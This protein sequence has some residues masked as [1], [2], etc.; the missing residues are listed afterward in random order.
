MKHGADP[1]TPVALVR[2][3]TRGN[4]QT[5]VGT[6]A[7]IADQVKAT[8]FQAPAVCVIG[9]VVK[10]REHINWFENRPLFGKRIIVTRT[11]HQ[12]GG[13][14]KHLG[15]LG[16]DVIELPTIKI[17]EPKNKMEFGELVQDC[18]TYDWIVFTS[19]NGVDAFFELFY[20]LY[21]DA[22][23]IGPAKIAVIGPGTA[24][25]VKAYHLAVD[26]MPDKFVAE[27]L[28][29]KFKD[30]ENIE[31]LK[32]L[33]VRAEDAREVIAAGL[34]KLGAIVDEAIA[35]RTV[36]ER[37]DNQ[38]AIA[39]MTEEGADLITFT[40]ASTVDCFF[41][42]GLELPKGIKIASIGP[43]T[44]EAVRKHKLKVDIEAKDY[45]IPGLVKA[46]QDHFAK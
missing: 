46:I 12:A 9:N 8:G 10:E 42:L 25:R 21:S 29:K 4:Q 3:A 39:R 43:V 5:L 1:Q 31:H 19:P 2:W 14:T 27:G 6:L 24:D 33:W 26:L 34:S 18:Y 13:L 23:S 41:A 11:R 30:D 16:A 15:Q 44:S 35:Y 28:I 7:T 22:R 36:P 38:A 40:S 20:K 45:S 37:E 17:T 32:V